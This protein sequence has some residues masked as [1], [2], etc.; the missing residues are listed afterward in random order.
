MMEQQE[1]ELGH[2]WKDVDEEDEGVDTLEGS[3]MGD[4]V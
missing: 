1:V 2:E 3:E 4:G